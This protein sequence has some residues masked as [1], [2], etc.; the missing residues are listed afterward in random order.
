MQTLR[1]WI[2]I[3][4]MAVVWLGSSINEAHAH[5]TEK[6]GEAIKGMENI[7][8]VHGLPGHLK[9][10][11]KKEMDRRHEVMEELLDAILSL[12]HAEVVKH[13]QAL[14]NDSL[15]K[16]ELSAADQ[17]TLK[18]QLPKGFHAL[19]NAMDQYALRVMKA[20][21]RLD[22]K[23]EVT[24]FGELF[25]QCTLCHVKYGGGHFKSKG[26]GYR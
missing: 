15:L 23:A 22:T 10:R 1:S 11:V 16:K 17:S 20:A 25:N 9:K 19:D 24:R 6:H 2:I 7:A 12:E 13:A 26:G 4:A 14:T 21:A 3:L 18:R 8:P 5:G